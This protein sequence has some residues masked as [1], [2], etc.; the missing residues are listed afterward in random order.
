MGTVVRELESKYEPAGDAAMPD[1][2]ALD[3]V[4]SVEEPEPHQLDA[5]YFDTRDLALSAAGVTL[6][7]RAGGS[8]AGWHL[9]VPAQNGGRDEL[10]EPLAGVPEDVVPEPLA[11]AIQLYTRGDELDAVVRLHTRRQTFLLH[12]ADGRTVAEVSDDL[13]TAEVLEQG[14]PSSTSAWRDWEVELVDGD[15]S[16]LDAAGELLQ[17]SGAL[18]ASAPSKLARAL[19]ERIPAPPADPIATGKPGS[20]TTEV[21]ASYLRE[22]LAEIKYRDPLVRRD[23][24]DAVHRMRVAIR[25]L[26]SVLASYRPL[27]DRDRTEPLRDEMKWIAG[28]L[29]DAR[30]AEVMH[31]R[32]NRLIAAEPTEQ[33]MGP[34]TR[35][36]DRQ[37]AAVYRR[38]HRRAVQAMES[39]RY[40]ALIDA[41]DAVVADPPWT[42]RAKGPATDVLPARVAKAYRR[43]RRRVDAAA[44]APD[45]SERDRRLHEV[46]KA[47]KRARYAAEPLIPLFGRD[48]KRFVKATKKVQSVLGDYQDAVVTQP[49]L[50]QLA[51]QAHLDGD[52]AFTFGRLHGRQQALAAGLRASYDEAWSR[53]KAKKRRKWLP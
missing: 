12:D 1:L 2:A 39:E 42:G 31:E 23:V 46:R 5:T 44:D 47:A 18:P 45:R 22:Q 15:E 35:R 43:L 36:V 34:V 20:K 19:G 38:A 33:V 48:A 16:L 21:V 53:V 27:F 30:D 41:L 4:A 9:K 52:N 25:R 3:G 17:A 50:R 8:D 26:R 10:R 6:R 14:E 28:V 24:P 37:F 7:R 49:A 29:G 40:Y 13:V 51:V 32:L 11:Q